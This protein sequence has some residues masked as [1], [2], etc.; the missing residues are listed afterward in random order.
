[1]SSKDGGPELHPN[2]SIRRSDAGDVETGVPSMT[3]K[4]G[5][6]RIVHAIWAWFGKMKGGLSRHPP[7]PP[8]ID[9]SKFSGSSLPY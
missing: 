9:V 5:T 4:E 6:R 1:M 7:S 3:A 8:F 2:P